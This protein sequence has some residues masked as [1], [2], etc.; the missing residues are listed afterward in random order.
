MRWVQEGFGS[1]DEWA[2]LSALFRALLFFEVLTGTAAGERSSEVQIDYGNTEQ[3]ERVRQAFSE[4]SGKLKGCAGAQAAFLI[5]ACCRR[6]E[7][8]QYGV[9]KATPFV[10]RYKGLRLT[11]EDVQ[12]LFVEAQAKAIDYGPEEEAKVRGL[13]TCAAAA[14]AAASE[15]WDLSPDEV[16]YFFALGRALSGRLAKGQE[17]QP[18]Q[19]EASQ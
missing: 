19:G 1:K 13:L 4:C 17:E 11:Q 10:S 12:K 16:S 2:A 8:I 5:A 7:Y 14:L 6:I 3:A 15:R 18:T 9:R